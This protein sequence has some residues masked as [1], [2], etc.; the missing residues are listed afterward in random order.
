MPLPTQVGGSDS[1]E[2]TTLRWAPPVS[3]KAHGWDHMFTQWEQSPV[4]SH[5]CERTQRTL[6]R[7]PSDQE[8]GFFHDFFRIYEG[9]RTK[10]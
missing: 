9:L 2:R 6:E 10:I 3:F 4:R 5:E 1:S 7:E 8:L